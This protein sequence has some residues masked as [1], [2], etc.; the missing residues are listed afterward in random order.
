MPHR[1][2]GF[3]IFSL[4]AA[5]MAWLATHDIIPAWTAQDPPRAVAS[6]WVARFGARSQ[7]GIF[8]HRD[9]RIGGIWST[10]ASGAATE[11][12]DEIYLTRFPL[13]GP[14][15]VYVKSMFDIEGALDELEVAILGDWHPIRIKGEVFA[16]KFAVHIDAGS[17]SHRQVFKIDGNLAGIISD[18]FR[19]FDAM[20]E[21]TIGQSWRMQV[22]NPV[23][24]V[25]GVGNQF[26]PM[27]ARVVG[28]ESIEVAGAVRDCFIVE[29]SQARAWVDMLSGKVWSQELRLPFGTFS[30][31]LETYDDDMRKAAARRFDTRRP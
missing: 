5:S 4:W 11:R 10:Y 17:I 18:A 16:S 28:S 21:L 7:Y 2:T 3:A 30:V 1:I 19:P 25:T 22:L 24:V 14:M 27:L 20:P 12:E 9:H 6:G 26:M 31:R 8:D 13:T 15:H 23:A 29:T